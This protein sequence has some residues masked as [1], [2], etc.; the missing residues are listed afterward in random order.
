MLHPFLLHVFINDLDDR[1][2]CSLS[3]C[4]GGKN[5][6]RAA[7]TAEG[8]AAVQR[9]F[10]KLEKRADITLTEFRERKCKVLNQ[11]RNNSKHLHVLEFT[12]Q[13]SSFAEKDLGVLGV[14]TLNTSN[15]A[16]Q[17]HT[18][19]ILGSAGRV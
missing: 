8:C 5:M 19:S 11:E 1:V 17:G 13:D 16:L 4:A 12:Q 7:D 10:D 2:G 18:N 14:R 3:K 15:G 6:E 9:D